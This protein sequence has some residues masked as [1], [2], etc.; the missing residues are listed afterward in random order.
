M[1]HKVVAYDYMSFERKYIFFLNIYKF[2]SE[3]TLIVAF[4]GYAILIVIF[5]LICI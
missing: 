2:P 4:S 3:S 5:N 1:I